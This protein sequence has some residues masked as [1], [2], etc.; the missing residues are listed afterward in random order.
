MPPENK[1]LLSKALTDDFYY[2]G[3]IKK[4]YT[5]LIPGA[6][7]NEINPYNLK[8]MGFQIFSKY[9]LQNHPSVGA[10]FEHLLTDGDI[11]DISSYRKRFTYVTGFSNKSMQLKRE[12]QVIEF[13]P[14]KLISMRRLASRGVR[15]EM[16][17]TFCDNVYNFVDAGEYFSIRSIRNDGFISELDD[18][19]F[20][21]WFY[22]NLLAFDCRFSF[23]IMYGC[24]ILFKGSKNITR[25]DYTCSLIRNHRS[26]D[27]Y[28]L[29]DEMSERFGCK[30]DARCD[31]LYVL[32]GSEIY[33]DEFL[34][35][36]YA[37][38]EVYYR[39][40]EDEGDF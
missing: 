27:T 14:N 15:R 13:E 24:I 30:V 40:L 2:T 10:Y 28:D 3:E 37:N 8:N 34:D 38:K 18:L 22:A 31:I 9:V 26:I 11:V 21:D 7:P 6:D 16:I 33:H 39:E 36:L 20:P 12:R 29:M 23:G 35:R 19:G 1:Q 4:I 25:A 5:Q 32:S 17:Q